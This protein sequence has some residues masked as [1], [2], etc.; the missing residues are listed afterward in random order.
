MSHRERWAPRSTANSTANC[1]P[2][3]GL[4]Q[5]VSERGLGTHGA[6]CC[7]SHTEGHLPFY[8]VSLTSIP[9]GFQRL[10]WRIMMLL[11]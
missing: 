1:A 5:R 6:N 4:V 2:S 11:I 9:W 10:L 7:Q 3:K 8:S